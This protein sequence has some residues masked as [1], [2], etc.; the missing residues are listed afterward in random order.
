MILLFNMDDSNTVLSKGEQ[1][2]E[3]LRQRVIAD[4]NFHPVCSMGITLASQAEHFEAVSR[5]A[6][7]ALYRAK[8][9]NKGGCCLWSIDAADEDSSRN[10][11]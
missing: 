2:C 4:T 5:R 11:D 8:K 1:I 7:M 3:K 6:D 10:P 9:T